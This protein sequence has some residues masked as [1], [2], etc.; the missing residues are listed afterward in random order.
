MPE[1]EPPE[2]PW[3]SARASRPS[4][5]LNQRPLLESRP[6]WH[7]LS[8]VARPGGTGRGRVKQAPYLGPAAPTGES[9]VE[10]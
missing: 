5:L 3:L 2:R 6:V 9:L 7:R 8:P 10:R 1:P 4:A